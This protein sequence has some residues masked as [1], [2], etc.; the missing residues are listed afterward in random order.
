MIKS[1]LLGTFMV[2]VLWMIDAYY[3][4]NNHGGVASYNSF[5]NTPEDNLDIIV[6]GNSHLHYGIDPIIIEAKIHQKTEMMVGG[7]LTIA[8][9]YYNL[10]E[11]L[12]YQSPKLVIIEAWPLISPDPVRNR[13]EHSNGTL[14][15]TKYG[16]EYFKRPGLTKFSEMFK[17]YPEEWPIRS[18]NML[19]AHD[20]W[21]DIKKSSAS[22]RTKLSKN[23]KKVF[24]NSQLRNT[25]LPEEKVEAY[26]TID[27]KL[28]QFALTQ[29]EIKY[30]NKILDLVDHNKLKLLF[31]TVP[32]YDE[33]YE[34]TRVA[35]DE[36]S[37][38]LEKHLETK[39]NVKFLDINKEFDGLNSTYIIDEKKVSYNQHLNYKGI[40]KT[41]NF[42]ANYILK[43][44]K[45][46]KSHGKLIRTPE[47]ILYN[48]NKIMKL[49]NLRGGIEMKVEHRD[50][51]LPNNTLRFDTNS[52]RMIIDGWMAWGGDSKIQDIKLALK[53]D[54]NYIFLSGDE[55]KV[56]KKSTNQN[57]ESIWNYRL[58]LDKLSIGK[59]KYRIYQAI[60]TTDEGWLVQDMWKWIIIE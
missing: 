28:D 18:F 46:P 59:G 34:M 41:S 48:K 56:L 23:P 36:V 33:Y 53:R 39:K 43:N 6:L 14:N 11:V 1:F 22:I 54:K 24:Q 8:Q 45:L 25:F 29:L 47:H 9:I 31:F 35:F 30:L 52:S 60:Q 40:V 26:R 10:K 15:V 17:T 7:G 20:N 3:L 44:Y 58:N 32:V 42:L 12:A 19:R 38:E 49:D 16:A 21:K 37:N 51:L 4:N 13:P 55:L 2:G 27:P 50:S 5:Y 57:A